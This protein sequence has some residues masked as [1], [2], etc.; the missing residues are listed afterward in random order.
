MPKQLSTFQSK[1]LNYFR[2]SMEIKSENG[3]EKNDYHSCLLLQ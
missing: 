1:L 3:V 2:N